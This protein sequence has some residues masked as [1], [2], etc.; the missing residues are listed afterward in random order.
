M[1]AAAHNWDKDSRVTLQ[2]HLGQFRI[3]A[4]RRNLQ[5]MQT[6]FEKIQLLFNERQPDQWELYKTNEGFDWTFQEVRRQLGE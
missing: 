1:A 6:A 2:G 5:E 4:L 3:N